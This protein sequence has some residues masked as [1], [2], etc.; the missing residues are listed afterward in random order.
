MILLMYLAYHNKHTIL[1][2]KLLGH[3]IR[4][5]GKFSSLLN[6]I[7]LFDYQLVSIRSNWFR[8]RILTALLTSN[9]LQLTCQ[10]T[11]QLY[12]KIL[13]SLHWAY[14]LAHV[15]QCKDEMTCAC[16]SQFQFNKL[17]QWTS[18]W[19]K[20]SSCAIRICTNY[21]LLCMTGWSNRI[22]K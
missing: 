16:V 18:L 22:F 20:Y 14:W 15:P 5:W 11:M 19:S 1:F 12:S 21:K 2:L 3:E 13:R 8:F 6:S 4:P 7:F 9:Q 10:S 17:I